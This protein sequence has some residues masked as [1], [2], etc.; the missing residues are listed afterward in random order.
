VEGPASFG[1]GVFSADRAVALLS[2]PYP[3]AEVAA[4]PGLF[5]LMT[6]RL[7][8][9]AALREL[10]DP[11]DLSYVRVVAGELRVGSLTRHA[12]LLGS[13]V[14]GERLAILRDL[15][16]V[17]AD[18]VVRCSA[19]VGGMLCQADPSEDLAAVL[20][21]VQASMVIRGREGLRTVPAREFCRGPYQT[22]VEPGELLAEIRI[23]IR[24]GGSA[25]E[26]A[27]QGAAGCPVTGAAAW[28]WLDGDTVAA[29]GL[30]I[31]PAAPRCGGTV[32]A[33]EFL[34]GERLM[35]VRPER[36]GQ[37]A[38]RHCG[39]SAGMGRHPARG[40]RCMAGELTTR[41]VRRALLRARRQ[42]AGHC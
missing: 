12:E 41:A 7:A 9:P 18:R 25:Y 17:V 34:A 20:A 1:H 38:A 4:E 6:L 10:G 19:T 8:G 24:P 22:V 33:E 30:G 35:Q 37:V 32:A 15:R 11:A 27:A 2:R 5:A 26:R 3:P 16:R 28:L 29:A 42:D 31:T 13:A 23:P 39:C 14:A 21:A 36:A 40:Q